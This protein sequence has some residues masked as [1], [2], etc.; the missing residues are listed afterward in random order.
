MF[1]WLFPKETDFFIYFDSHAALVVKA[2]SALKKWVDEGVDQSYEIKALEHE[3]DQVLHDC[4]EKLHKTFITPFGREDIHRLISCLDD[5]LDYID[6]VAER[7]SIYKIKEMTPEAKELTQVLFLI[8]QKFTPIFEKLRTL[9]M[10]PET[11]EIIVKI[12]ALE[13]RGDKVYLNAIKTLFDNTSD[14]IEIMKWKEIYDR[15]ENAIDGAE[16][17]AYIVE[18]IILESN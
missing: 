5:I 12:N 17:I 1:N 4:V 18:G 10:N 13:N 15:L 7:L 2:A 16:E 8:T 14:A 11:K 6:E 9:K 3:G